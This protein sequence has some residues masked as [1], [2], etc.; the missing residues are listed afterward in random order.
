MDKEFQKIEEFMNRLDTHLKN[1]TDK[2]LYCDLTEDCVYHYTSIQSFFSGIISYNEQEKRVA[3]SLMAT[4][5]NYLNDPKEFKYGKNTADLVYKNLGYP[6][7]KKALSPVKQFF[8]TS[9]SKEKDSIPMWHQYGQGGTGVALGFKVS[10]MPRNNRLSSC[11]YG[12]DEIMSFVR[13][14]VELYKKNYPT[15]YAHTPEAIMSHTWAIA[16]L[17]SKHPSYSYEKEVRVY[18]FLGIDGSTHYRL[19][20]NLIVPFKLLTYPLESLVKV[21]VGPCADPYRTRKSI[22]DY[23]DSVGLGHVVV[24]LSKAPYRK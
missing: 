2:R 12:T 23:L 10:A 8:L 14:T 19:S 5:S 7:I 6:A 17:S 13:D 21:I 3:I 18:T 4:D 9:F 16:A 1:C 11:L 20:N 22:R 15:D 24:E